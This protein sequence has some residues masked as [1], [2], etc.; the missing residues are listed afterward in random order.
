M[1]TCELAYPRLSLKT[2]KGA[3]GKAHNPWAVCIGYDER[4]SCIS[5]LV[6]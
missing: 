4:Q 5:E 6:G 1:D 2:N 3:H